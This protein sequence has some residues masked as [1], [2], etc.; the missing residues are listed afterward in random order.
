MNPEASG[1]ISFGHMRLDTN[2]VDDKGKLNETV[3]LL[4]LH[5][6]LVQLNHGLI[7]Y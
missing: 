2:V 6:V 4:R 3:R 1:M 5:M 7:I